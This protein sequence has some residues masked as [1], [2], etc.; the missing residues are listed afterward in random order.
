MISVPGAVLPFPKA[1]KLCPP[2]M[3]GSGRRGFAASLF[4][5]LDAGI[6]PIT[7]ALRSGAVHGR[8]TVYRTHLERHSI[9][10]WIYP[11]TLRTSA[12]QRLQ[13]RTAIRPSGVPISPS[14]F[15]ALA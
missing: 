14:G 6:L 13:T 10:I 9:P 15:E 12:R 5:L 7:S 4:L 11:Q 1:T 8:L 2:S 3:N